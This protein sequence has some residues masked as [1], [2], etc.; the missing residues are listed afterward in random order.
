[1]SI[2][3][4]I[5]NFDT[6]NNASVSAEFQQL[7]QELVQGIPDV[8]AI[9]C[10]FMK[11]T[12]WNQLF[13]L[14]LTG[15][16]NDINDPYNE[17]LK[18]ELDICATALYEFANEVKVINPAVARLDCSSNGTSGYLPVNGV[19]SDIDA[20]YELFFSNS[21]IQYNGSSTAITNKKLV[22]QDYVRFLAEEVLENA[23]NAD[24]FDNESILRG[25]I[26]SNGYSLWVNILNQLYTSTN[27]TG[28]ILL[29]GVNISDHIACK[30]L[31]TFARA[32]RI[33]PQN[34][35]VFV[36][37][38]SALSFFLP[39][40]IITCKFSIVST[41]HNPDNKVERIPTTR[42]YKIKICLVDE[43]EIIDDRFVNGFIDNTSNNN[44]YIRHGQDIDLSNTFPIDSIVDT[45]DP[46]LATNLLNHNS[47]YSLASTFNDISGLYS[48]PYWSAFIIIIGKMPIDGTTAYNLNRDN[49]VAVNN[50][51][52]F[53]YL[54]T[55]VTT[56][57]T[58]TATLDLLEKN[59]TTHDAAPYNVV[60]LTTET[61]Y[62]YKVSKY[63]VIMKELGTIQVTN[64][65]DETG[66]YVI[67]M[68]EASEDEVIDGLHYYGFFYGVK[69]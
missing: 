40:D 43:K 18:Y 25:D 68:N 53:Y 36:N 33:T 9:A 32:N 41:S 27:S 19:S 55:P 39:G 56:T 5:N 13:R 64:S 22:C 4:Y 46:T 31:R 63:G 1:M 45:L 23:N 49:G 60:G 20:S 2:E 3:I 11:N 51:T 16:S 59:G 66:G 54:A 21:A 14:K 50:P 6:V 17:D 69:V 24:L 15:D 61:Y 28:E 34:A 47:P 65:G 44:E 10:I 7:P 29:T 67:K 62:Y 58:S 35:S 37:D 26:E 38:F 42:T 52:P 48:T 8:S 57:T 12:S 30:V